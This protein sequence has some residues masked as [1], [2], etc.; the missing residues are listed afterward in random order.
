MIQS[1]RIYTKKKHVFF[2][3]ARKGADIF[4]GEKSPSNVSVLLKAWGLLLPTR[5]KRCG[6]QLFVVPFLEKTQRIDDVSPIKKGWFSSETPCLVSGGGDKILQV[7]IHRST[8][9]PLTLQELLDEKAR[10]WQSLNAKRYGEKRKLGTS[11][12]GLNGPLI[13]ESH[14]FN[15]WLGAGNSNIFVFT[16]NYRGDDPNLTIITFFQMGWWKTTNHQ[17]YGANLENQGIPNTKKT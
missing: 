11:A 2:L 6:G 17:W 15:V 10:K 14:A 3:A 8:G 5:P 7:S 9:L 13:R 1:L 4:G 16:P 12:L